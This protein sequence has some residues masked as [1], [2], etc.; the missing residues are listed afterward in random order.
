MTQRTRSPT[1]KLSSL[2]C[3]FFGS[4]ASVLPRSTTM[5][6]PSTRFTVQLTSSPTRPEYS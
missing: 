4:R 2:D 3:S 1:L 6:C 5:S